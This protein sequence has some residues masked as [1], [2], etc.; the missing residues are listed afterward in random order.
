MGS[1]N[2]FASPIEVKKQVRNHELW[3]TSEPSTTILH[4][5][6]AYDGP[7]DLSS[8]LH[9]AAQW[10]A[11]KKG[12][13]W[14]TARRGIETSNLPIEL[15]R[16]LL[17]VVDSL[18]GEKS[19]WSPG[20]YGGFMQRISRLKVNAEF[21]NLLRDLHT[22]LWTAS[23]AEKDAAILAALQR[24]PSGLGVSRLSEYLVLSDP[25]N[26]PVINQKSHDRIQDLI[27][28]RIPDSPAV[29]YLDCLDAARRY[30][31]QLEQYAGLDKLSFLALDHLVT[32]RKTRLPDTNWLAQQLGE[33]DDVMT[34]TRPPLQDPRQRTETS[35][36]AV[37]YVRQLLEEKY[38]G[39]QIQKMRPN[40][41][42]YD[43]RVLT[44]NGE[45]FY[46]EVKGTRLDTP[47]FFLTETERRF[48]EQK[49]DN[50]FLYIVTN[51][52]GEPTHCEIKDPFG[53]NMHLI[54][55][56]PQSYQGSVTC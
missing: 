31:Q 32:D 54:E 3:Y 23:V 12:R 40:N 41:P 52:A 19:K 47:W 26:Y 30:R 10:I 42:G 27:C 21:L 35:E 50:Y 44:E 29:T 37:E 14:S 56:T 15:R 48:G 22:S 9:V 34:F 43:I 1:T 51:V 8:C 16:R 11:W 45:Q 33:T 6:F 38:P 49:G 13:R 17:D 55:L 20:C 25:L 7:V 46:I 4:E 5:L 24:N 36:T 53:A 2:R 39:S 28:V 18:P